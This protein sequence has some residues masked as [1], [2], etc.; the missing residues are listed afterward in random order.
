M[1]D[2]AHDVLVVVQHGQRRDTFAVHQLQRIRERLVAIDGYDLLRADPQIVQRSRI[3]RF[4]GGKG[5]MVVPEKPHQS[6]LAQHTDHLARAFL[7]NHHSVD[8]AAQGLHGSR[9]VGRVRQKRWP[10]S[11]AKMV[12][13]ILQRDCF[14]AAG[15]LGQSRCTLIRLREA[16]NKQQVCIEVGIVER[17]H[18]GAS[19]A[20]LADQHHI[21]R[22]RPDEQLRGIFDASIQ[23]HE[24]HPSRVDDLLDLDGSPADRRGSSAP[25]SAGV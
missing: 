21:R 17:A 15:S 18:R 13:H 4:G 5:L 22:T 24:S 8:A 14:T 25:P 9:Q 11:R 1:A 6:Q 3:Q 20:G 16:Q 12:D 2:I 10:F 7:A 23:L 19:L